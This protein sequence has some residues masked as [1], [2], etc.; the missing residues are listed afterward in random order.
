MN[1]DLRCF[2]S[3]FY[4]LVNMVQLCMLRKFCHNLI[5]S[6]SKCKDNFL[7]RL[8][9]LLHHNRLYQ[10][11]K[12]ILR[13]LNWG[14]KVLARSKVVLLKY[15]LL[16]FLTTAA[17]QQCFSLSY[18]YQ[19][20]SPQ[21]II[22]KSLRLSALQLKPKVHLLSLKRISSQYESVK[23]LFRLHFFDP[24]TFK[25]LYLVNHIHTYWYLLSNANH[26]KN[27]HSYNLCTTKIN[28][29]NKTCKYVYY[30]LCIS[31]W[32]SIQDFIF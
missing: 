6:H 1:D 16:K 24:S 30:E 22:T 8:L 7:R 17:Y 4:L 3:K 11:S 21:A 25:A 9:V 5:E 15:F 31:G 19:M 10:L 29:K 13:S 23:F 32:V 20:E 14:V 26:V 2:F 18:I 12:L 27:D 28:R